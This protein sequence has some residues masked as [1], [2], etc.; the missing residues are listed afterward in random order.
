MGSDNFMSAFFDTFRIN[1][2]LFVSKK[3]KLYECVF[4]Y[5]DVTCWGAYFFAAG[6]PYG[7]DVMFHQMF[8]LILK[9]LLPLV[10]MRGRFIGNIIALLISYS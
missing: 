8:Q 1:T 10:T 3:S 4:Q 7:R 9:N 6:Y 5:V 2:A